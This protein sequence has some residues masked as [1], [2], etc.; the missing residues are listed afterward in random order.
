[1]EM[2][3]EFLI[4]LLK[5]FA[6]GNITDEEK[7]TLFELLN[8]N[9]NSNFPNDLFKEFWN[10]N[11][12]DTL[13]VNSLKIWKN[14]KQEISGDT[15]IDLY[16]KANFIDSIY[17]LLKYAAI[18]FIIVIIGIIFYKNYFIYNNKGKLAKSE[19]QYYVPYGSKSNIQLSDGTKIWLNSGS[20]IKFNNEYGITNRSVFLEG[21]AYFE[22]V[23]NKKFP[24]CVNVNGNLVIKAFGTKFNVKSFKEDNK[25]ET[26]L[27]SGS[28]SIEKLDNKGKV[29]HNIIMKPNELVAYSKQE[30]KFTIIREKQYNNIQ[31]SVKKVKNIELIANPFISCEIENKI[32]W[33][34]NRLVF[35]SE[36]IESI[37]LKLE[38]WY[39]VKIIL[40]NEKLKQFRFTGSF[41]NETIEQALEALR[42]TAPFDY[43]IKKNK[44]TIY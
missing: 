34:N 32:A 24:F 11:Y 27:L 37:I 1:M 38:R 36:D 41:D 31:L 19:Y 28:V 39:N 14:I 18:V 23:T 4:E 42:L 26:I 6:E 17:N 30:D 3:R 7:E 9:E 40:K 10:K 16:R 8:F 29:I 35:R 43:I 15:K 25:I 33:K 20:L 21:E 44:I 13:E 22:V 2:K 5:K 12:N